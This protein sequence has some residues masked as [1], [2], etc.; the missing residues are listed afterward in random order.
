MHHVS[1][2]I[3]LASASPR[4]S[5]LMSLA[6]IDFSIHPADIRE[7]VLENELPD[8]HVRRLSGEKARAAAKQTEG[9]F[10]IGADTV[11]ALDGVIMGKPVDEAQAMAML[12][13]LSGRTHL[14]LTGISVFDRV[15][16]SCLTE[17]VT[18]EVLFK[19]LNDR[20]IRSYIATG[21]PMDKAGAYAIQGGSG[22]F[23]P[24]HHR[25]VH[26]CD[27]P[28]HDGVIRTAATS[29]GVAITFT[30]TDLRYAINEVPRCLLPSG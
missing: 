25:F 26:Q 21:C 3:V 2:P 20:E 5:E 30:S 23:C 9:R 19:T 12:T 28:A 1:A 6:G 11:V 29:Q 15:T 27:R 18:T 10:F 14:V 16:D 17:C 8:D 4:R 7:D 24:F 13:A 22:S